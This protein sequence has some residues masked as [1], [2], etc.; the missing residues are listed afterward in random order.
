MLSNKTIGVSL[1]LVLCTDE[2]DD[3]KT[4]SVTF[5]TASTLRGYPY[6]A[7]GSCSNIQKQF[8]SDNKQSVKLI[9]ISISNEHHLQQTKY[10]I[11][12]NNATGE[13]SNDYNEG[14]AT[15]ITEL[16]GIT[17]Y[18]IKKV[19][20]LAITPKEEE[21]FTGDFYASSGFFKNKYGAFS[22]GMCTDVFSLP[23]M[24]L[25]SKK[26]SRPVPV[27]ILKRTYKNNNA[28]V[29]KYYAYKEL[30][31]GDY[32]TITAENTLDYCNCM[33]TKSLLTKLYYTYGGTYSEQTKSCMYMITDA[34]ISESADMTV[35]ATANPD[36][37]E[38]NKIIPGLENFTTLE[39]VNVAVIRKYLRVSAKEGES[40][41]LGDD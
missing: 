25:D 18:K 41:S 36:P 6:K 34:K 7:D 9:T 2:S 1:R 14:S 21:Y 29:T 32:C 5:S 38:G 8:N 27:Q 39:T 33:H 26:N 37:M 40:L 17:C 24:R 23:W 15:E 19:E 22:L 30:R 20:I 4:K 3:T 10:V 11:S 13:S 28:E 35:N 12:S 16:S 31:K